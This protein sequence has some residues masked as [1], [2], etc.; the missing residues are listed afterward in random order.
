MVWVERKLV[1][2]LRWQIS[3]GDSQE[4][5]ASVSFGKWCF[6]E[7]LFVGGIAQLCDIG[8]MLA[9]LSNGTPGLP[10]HYILKNSRLEHKD[11]RMSMIK[12]RTSVLFTRISRSGKH[13]F[14][15]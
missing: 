15:V 11:N 6:I 3:V 13:E 8:K 9:L 7:R 1:D 2:S 10:A 4:M 14:G 5:Y 12:L